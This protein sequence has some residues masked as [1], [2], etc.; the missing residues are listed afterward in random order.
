MAG[1]IAQL[2]NNDGTSL[3]LS[4][5]SK[6]VPLLACV[7][8]KVVQCC[9]PKPGHTSPGVLCDTVGAELRHAGPA[10]RI[11]GTGNSPKLRGRYTGPG[12]ATILLIGLVYLWA[13]MSAFV[14][15]APGTPPDWGSDADEAPGPE[16]EAE[17]PKRPAPV[18]AFPR[19]W[20]LPLDKTL[21]REGLFE[22]VSE[23]IH[24]K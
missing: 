12:V 17:Y 23:Y 15:E 4:S 7:L 24:R 19:L 21:R 1:A 8:G 6:A 2:C 5:N 9:V 14:E 13:I 22:L 20:S 11:R 3:P 18:N 16:W 10:D